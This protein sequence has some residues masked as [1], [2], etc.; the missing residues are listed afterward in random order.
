MFKFF[1]CDFHY[2]M[3]NVSNSE[4]NR[5][6]KLFLFYLVHKSLLTQ[7]D[8][9]NLTMSYNISWTFGDSNR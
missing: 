5:T 6:L 1:G 4:K 7:C 9:L 8:S 2:E 3:N